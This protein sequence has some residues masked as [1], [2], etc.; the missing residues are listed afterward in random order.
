ML[1]FALL[2]ILYVC[3]GS[4]QNV[5]APLN[6]DRPE[7]PPR[8]RCCTVDCR[9]DRCKLVSS[10]AFWLGFVGVV[11]G[12]YWIMR[13]GGT[14]PPEA[15]ICGSH[16]Y[17]NDPFS[18][19]IANQSRVKGSG[20]CKVQQIGDWL[21]CESIENKCPNFS[22]EGRTYQVGQNC[23]AFQ[24]EAIYRQVQVLRVTVCSFFCGDPCLP[25]CRRLPGDRSFKSADCFLDAEFGVL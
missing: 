15:P 18:D 23:A 7:I 9:S 22:C 8:R 4:P 5:G 13:N 11:C 20:E 3:P 2:S 24:E 14:C 6:I 19:G 16:F 1:S 21:S 12:L 17:Y 25:Y 10:A